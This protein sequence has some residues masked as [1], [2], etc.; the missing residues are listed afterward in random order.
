[1]SNINKIFFATFLLCLSNYTLS[2]NTSDIITKRFLREVQSNN[3]FI[4]D[5]VKCSSGENSTCVCPGACMVEPTTG[6]Y[7]TL[8]KCWK[9]N[10]NEAKCQGSGPD[11]TSAIVLQAIPFTGAFGSGFG[12]MGRWDL[13]AIPMGVI[14]GGL[15]LLCV[16]ACCLVGCSA[17]SDDNDGTK[18]ATSQVCGM[19]YGCLWSVAILSLWIWG[20]VM[21]AT[22]GVKGP[23]GCPLV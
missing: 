4:T 8:K 11:F 7:C 1:M 6:D 15:V 2:Q 12:N 18:E 23:N 14:F 16:L 9:W 21:I 5:K 10:V 22:R 17:N 3:D 13:F 20:I 19:C